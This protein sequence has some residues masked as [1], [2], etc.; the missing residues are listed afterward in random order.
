MREKLTAL[1]PAPYIAVTWRGGTAP[2][3]QGTVWV[4]HKAIALP[5]LADT[6]SAVPGT[7]IAVQRHPVPGEIAAL[8]DALKRPVHD[9]T[10]LNE[11]LEGMLALLSLLDDYVGM[12]NT[13]MHLRAAVGKTA[14]V[15]VPNPAEWRWLQSGR[16]S[17]WFPGFSIYRQSLNG[18]WTTACHNLKLDLASAH[19]VRAPGL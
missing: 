17:P 19:G 7:L 8:E 10:A 13:N 9:F 12:S 6:L 18:E 2:E 16:A 15:L 14:R 1:G 11:D 3:A 4:L 5:A